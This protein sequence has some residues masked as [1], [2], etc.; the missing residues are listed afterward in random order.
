LKAKWLKKQDRD[1]ILRNPKDVV[2]V[3]LHLPFGTAV[4]NDFGLWGR[5][6]ELL[7]SCGDQDAEACSR[8]I[9]DRLWESIRAD[10]EA[11]LVRRLDCQFALVEQLQIRYAG[12]F[13]LRIG[14]IVTQMGAQIGR[15]LE[16]G[17]PRTAAGCDAALTLSLKGRPNRDCWSRA[18]FSEDG[19]DPVSLQRFLGWFSWRNGFRVKHSPPALDLD[20]E[21]KCA[22][23]QRPTWFEP[24]RSGGPPNKPLQ[25]TSGAK[26]EVE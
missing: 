25:P 22:W 1:W 20:F 2:T 4:R 8:V 3:E 12:F 21:T 15:Q 5:N 6:A 7:A 19:R 14:E 10:A 16:G 17:L 18:E 24:G 23:P 26:T 9:F 13:K 11:E